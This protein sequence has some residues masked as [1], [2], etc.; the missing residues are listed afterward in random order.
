MK[1]KPTPLVHF[2][3]RFYWGV[4]TSA[5]QVEGGNHNQWSVWEL[6]NAQV[7]AEQAKYQT[8]HMPAWEKVEAEATNPSNYISGRA[9]DHYNR[10]QEDFACIKALNMNASRFGIEWSR[11]E[12]QEGKWNAEAIQHYRDYLRALKAK[13]IEPF[14]TLWHWTMPVWFAQKGGFAKRRN[15]KYFVRF[16]EK[17]FEEL[18]REFR[19][20]ITI[21]EPEVYMAKS[22][23]LGE[24]PPQKQSKWLS[25]CV[26]INLA[27]AHNKVHKL[28]RRTSRKFIVGLA[29]NCAHHYAGDNAWLSKYSAAIATWAADYFFLHFVRRRLDFIGLN[30]YFSNRYYGYRVHN[31]NQDVS[32][33]GW[34]MQPQHIQFVLERLHAKYKIPIIVTENGCADRDDEFRQWWIMQTLVA[35]HKALQNGVRLEGYLHWSLTDNFEWAMGFWPRFGLVAIDY[36]T[37]TRHIRPSARWFGKVIKQMRGL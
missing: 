14:V 10:Y 13:N 18:G 1:P 36:Q 25:L 8:P 27:S 16:A 2:P 35:M 28:A 15:I 9:S 7:L 26:Y 29:K 34:D 32:D 4:S 31:P 12:P 19:Y 20:V 33:V 17:V 24:W 30:Y 21:N 22:Y 37:Q 11:V 5:H 23:A 3:K 6:Q